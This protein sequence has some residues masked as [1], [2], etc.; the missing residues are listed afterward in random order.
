MN[1]RLYISLQIS[2]FISSFLLFNIAGFSKKSITI[3][4]SSPTYTE[5]K[6][7][8]HSIYSSSNLLDN[9]GSCPQILNACE[10][11]DLNGSLIICGVSS[12]NHD[13]GNKNIPKEE[14][15]VVVSHVRQNPAL[16]SSYEN[17]ARVKIV[18]KEYI[19]DNFKPTSIKSPLL[20]I[21]IGSGLKS[22]FMFIVKLLRQ[23]A[24]RMW[25]RYDIYPSC[26]A[27]CDATRRIMIGFLGYNLLPK[28]GNENRNLI[29]GVPDV[30]TDSNENSI[31]LGRPMGVKVAIAAFLIKNT[32]S[33]NVQNIN[34]HNT[35][36]EVRTI[37][38]A[39]V[40]SDRLLL[41][42]AMGKNHDKANV[43]LEK[44][45]QYGIDIEKMKIMLV[46]V[47]REV[48]LETNVFADNEYNDSRYDTFRDDF[49]VCE[50]V[51]KRGIVNWEKI[52]LI[53][54]R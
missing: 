35:Y 28:C 31:K 18:A 10:A 41:A 13:N 46:S 45:Y 22:D 29:T 24:V 33:K 27:F 19:D 5:D 9:F 11:S 42:V 53:P 50:V 44:R 7:H 51:T 38:P 21:A 49:I 30:L 4:S 34:K 36:I 37:N 16:T 23:W 26:L 20:V 1:Q 14:I 17:Y 3:D 40:V 47:M 54:I 12:L 8:T 48:L 25:E 43:L 32:R 52:P 6:I 2:I 15:I 39:G